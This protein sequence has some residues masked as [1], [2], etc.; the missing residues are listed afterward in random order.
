MGGKCIS[1]G[2]P[3]DIGDWCILCAR[4]YI[5]ATMNEIKAIKARRSTAVDKE[6]NPCCRICKMP[7]ER[8]WMPGTWDHSGDEGWRDCHHSAEP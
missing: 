4:L 6:G 1:C 5:E 7:I 3:A 2:M 8:G